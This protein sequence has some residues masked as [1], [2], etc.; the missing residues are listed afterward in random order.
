MVKIQIFELFGS[1]LLHDEGVESK[2]DKIDKKGQ[3]TSKGMGLSF[4]NMA[5]AALKFAS[6]I[7]A[8]LGMKAVYD[9]FNEG[10]K[11]MAQM[12][13]VLKSTKSAAGMT[14]EELI[15]LADAQGRL[16]LFD[17]DANIATEN[18][19]LTFTKI[20]KDVFP[21]TLK[22]VNDMS[23]AL[24]QDT[25][26]SAIQL[27]KALQDPILGITALSRVGVNFTVAQKEQIKTL[28][29]SGKTMEA[30]KIIL[31]EL[32]T[33]F[34]GSAEAA[35]K[36]L[37]GQLTI[38]KN[39]LLNIGS[40]I[41]EKVLP[42]LQSFVGNIIDNMPK[43]QEKVTSVINV[44]VPKFQE[45]MGLIGQIIKDL[46]PNFGKQ[47]DGVKD[48]VNVFKDALNVITDVL[49]FVKDNIELVRVA[50]ISLGVV[51]VLHTGYIIAQNVAL[52]AHNV[53]MAAHKIAQAANILMNGTEATTT[54]LAT[55][56][57]GLHKAAV[58]LSTAATWLFNAAMTAFNLVMSLNPIA[59]VILALAALGLGI[60]A[61]VKNWD[62]ISSAISK[63]WDWLTKWNK[64]PA[65]DK[66]TTV[67]TDYVET[68]SK[69]GAARGYARGYASGTD[70]ATPGAHWVGENGPEIV[71]FR[72]GE[73]V[74]NARD[75]AKVGGTN[76]TNVTNIYL[77]G[78]Q[79]A[80]VI[81]PYQYQNQQKRS[82]GQVVM[83]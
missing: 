72:G 12:E 69:G 32:T 4:G 41:L 42:P 18:L 9:E 63:A 17:D 34:G 24:G 19:L 60:L 25:K 66:K 22:V 38:M 33:E 44:I 80:Q 83:A 48:K 1:V 37:P 31:S 52:A 76:T 79:I 7:G 36:T 54:G 67:T 14:K 50:L 70:Y 59:L 2:L 71:N 45:W 56:A 29:E 81:A 55:V 39:S 57:L 77:D 3:S 8:G 47:T 13:S 65:K 49:K 30:Q 26:S 64:E 20:G 51:W 5:S 6:V 40:S 15:K 68:G 82:R 27:G 58:V 61:V 21:T 46:F 28:V 10:Q 74:T 75:S 43:I 53:T 73:T 23:Q 62:K 16:T 78:K 11:G 35:G